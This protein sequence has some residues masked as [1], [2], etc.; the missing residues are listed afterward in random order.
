MHGR[1][2]ISKIVA[3][4]LVLFLL[5]GCGGT[6]ASTTVTIGTFNQPVTLENGQI[7][8]T[9]AEL[10]NTGERYGVNGHIPSQFTATYHFLQFK[11]SIENLTDTPVDFSDGS[12]EVQTN[13]KD[14]LDS[15]ICLPE[16][17]HGSTSIDGKK[18]VEISIYYLLPNAAQQFTLRIK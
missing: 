10:I 1:N 2:L 4:T 9:L 18:V 7:K 12:L 8:V 5:S 6:T 11:L 14:L 15:G 16:C 17:V 3:L 13:A